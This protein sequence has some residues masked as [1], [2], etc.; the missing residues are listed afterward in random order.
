MKQI[1][2]NSLAQCMDTSW[3]RSS[4]PKT[5]T[6]SVKFSLAGDTV[7]ASYQALV[8]LVTERQLIELKRLY[9]SESDAVIEASLKNVQKNYK[10]LTGQ[11]IKFTQLAYDDGI[12][13]INMNSHNSR[14]TAL[15]RRKSVFEL[16]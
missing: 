1:D 5:A 16:K 13:V 7:V 14:R 2:L 10:E 9:K 12:E 6:M 11:T 4:M 15:Y 8:T 3:G